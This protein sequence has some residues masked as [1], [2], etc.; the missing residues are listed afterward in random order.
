MAADAQGGEDAGGRFLQ[1]GPAFESVAPGFEP[2]PT[3][4]RG[5]A[6]PAEGDE[7]GYV[8]V[9]LGGCGGFG[10][11]LRGFDP[12]PALDPGK[13]IGVEGE[14][15]TWAGQL[16]ADMGEAGVNAADE[17]I[18][19]GLVMGSPG[20]VVGVEG[21]SEGGGDLADPGFEGG[22]VEGGVDEFVQ[23]LVVAFLT[24]G[25]GHHGAG[26]ATAEGRI[27][28]GMGVHAPAGA[29]HL[30]EAVGHE[31]DT[32]G[33]A[34][35]EETVV[36]PVDG[37]PVPVAQEGVHGEE[38]DEPVEIEH[39]G[40]AIPAEGLV[41]IGDDV[42]EA[43]EGGMGILFVTGRDSE[44]AI[45]VL[46][47]SAVVEIAGHV[48]KVGAEEGFAPAFGDDIDAEVA[49]IDDDG[50]VMGA[51][52]GDSGGEEHL[53]ADHL[54]EEGGILDGVVEGDLGVAVELL[55]LDVL[56]EVEGEGR[57]VVVGAEA[58]GGALEMGGDVGEDGG[59][60]ADG[61]LDG[62]PMGN[63][64]LAAAAELLA[65]GSEGVLGFGGELEFDAPE[66]GRK[67]GTGTGGDLFGTPVASFVV[68]PLF[69]IP[70]APELG[71]LFGFLEEDEVG[72]Q[73]DECRP[74]HHTHH[75]P[76]RGEA[77]SLRRS[78]RKWRRENRGKRRGN[79]RR[80]HG[81]GGGFL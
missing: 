20:G 47:E 80:F 12:I 22:G 31:D 77:S 28:G 45:D 9:G 37:I 67:G 2:D 50:G 71:P 13:A 51:G 1:P 75:L 29:E 32:F 64:E 3:A 63:L 10:A 15:F 26:D 30:I 25:G 78:R 76:R 18:N 44:V 21:G 41:G 46:D 53:A 36:V 59:A 73:S 16:V 23:A 48:G 7:Q 65:M 55:T 60:F 14:G 17:L 34:V 40:Q 74:D 5:I 39:G 49:V 4:P 70:A 27:N 58:S 6:A 24:F 33:G 72:E 43:E 69:L 8:G 62:G 57:G 61:D 68:S 66:V 11:V 19:A 42:D 54:I 38:G 52:N 81:G 56:G 35:V 79:D